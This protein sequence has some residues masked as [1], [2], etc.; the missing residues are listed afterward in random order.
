MKPDYPWFLISP[1][2]LIGGAI[3]A[4]IWRELG[5]AVFLALI[6]LAMLGLWCFANWIMRDEP[7]PP[8]E[9]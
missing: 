3:W 4:L 5:A 6:A 7:V 8:E 1:G 2:A 9:P